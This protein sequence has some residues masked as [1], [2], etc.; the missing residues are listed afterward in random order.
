MDAPLAIPGQCG[1]AGDHLGYS[2]NLRSQL[3]RL[4]SE[5]GVGWQHL[6]RMRLYVMGSVPSD[7]DRTCRD[8]RGEPLL[9][10]TAA[11]AISRP[12]TFINP[13]LMRPTTAAMQR[14]PT[15]AW[16]RYRR[17]PDLFDSI[18][19]RASSQADTSELK[20]APRHTSRRSS[21]TTS[22][23]AP[24]SFAAFGERRRRRKETPQS[25]PFFHTT[26]Q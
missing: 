15:G 1:D 25:V 13:V 22:A 10:G 18:V 23:G 21:R 14:T 3:P 5:M 2:P 19:A 8:V 6:F 17:R 26:R 4:P 12:H 24:E 11:E 20:T 9:A 7:D 16:S